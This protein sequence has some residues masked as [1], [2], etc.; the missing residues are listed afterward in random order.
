MTQQ[1]LFVEQSQEHDVPIPPN[2]KIWRSINTD[3]HFRPKPKNPLITWCCI[4]SFPL[5]VCCCCLF[6]SVLGSDS[7]T[8]FT[9]VYLTNSQRSLLHVFLYL[10]ITLTNY[11][12]LE[13]LTCSIRKWQRPMFHKSFIFIHFTF[14]YNHFC[15]NNRTFMSFFKTL[16]T[17]LKT[18]IICYTGIICYNVQNLLPSYL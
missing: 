15:T 18:V 14:H 13:Y 9:N 6:L 1:K 7:V 4:F 10:Y 2:T 16:D 8:L 3:S 17:K 5:T 11:H 12:Y